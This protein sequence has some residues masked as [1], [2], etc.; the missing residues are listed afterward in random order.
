MLR[1]REYRF[2]VVTAPAKIVVTEPDRVEQ[3]IA[4]FHERVE[5]AITS[6]VDEVFGE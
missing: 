2:K 3:A 4:R 5:Q 6:Q 1:R